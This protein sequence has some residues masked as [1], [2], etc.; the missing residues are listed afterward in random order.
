M[1]TQRTDKKI[2]AHVA[3]IMD[4]NRRWAKARG[5]KEI[6]GH[7]RGVER[8]K[9]LVKFAAKTGIKS[10]TF[11]AFSTENWSRSKSFLRDILWLFRHVLNERQDFFEEL[12]QSGGEVHI[13]G[14]ISK[15]PKDIVKKIN[16]YLREP[17]PKDKIIDVNIALNY[18]GRDELL[19]AFKKIVAKGYN[20][21]QI[22]VDLINRYLDT[23]GQPDV[24]LM[25]RTGGERRTSGYLLWQLNYA[26]LYFTKTYFPDFGTKEFKKALKD[27][28]GR[29]RRFG[30]DSKRQKETPK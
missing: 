11:W 23:A 2:P 1:T 22:T 21:S 29:D 30:G 24:D 13:L 7:K 14:D 3:I 8:I 19:R 25:I 6:E 4:G 10:V 28:A 12:T 18:G 17:G 20:A 26:E 15:F 9:E 5:L 27:Y 16:F